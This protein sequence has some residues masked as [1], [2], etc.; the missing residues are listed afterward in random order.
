VT[1][2]GRR[3]RQRELQVRIREVAYMLWEAAGRDHGRAL[4]FWLAAEQEVLSAV[5]L[6]PA[7]SE[8]ESATAKGVAQPHKANETEPRGRTVNRS[9]TESPERK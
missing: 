5:P 8:H 2:E 9:A 7:R 6:T 4:E 3:R 1:D